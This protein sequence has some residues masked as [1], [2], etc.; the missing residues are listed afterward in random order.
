[1]I[2]HGKRGLVPDT[3]MAHGGAWNVPVPAEVKKKNGAAMKSHHKAKMG[4]GSSDWA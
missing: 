1:M 4:D 3:D 2:S